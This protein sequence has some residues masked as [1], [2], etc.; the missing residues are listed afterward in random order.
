MDYFPP[1]KEELRDALEKR[2]IEHKEGIYTDGWCCTFYENI[3]SMTK[4]PHGLY[5]MDDPIQIK[6]QNF[7]NEIKKAFPEKYHSEGVLSSCRLTEKEMD[8]LIDLMH[9]LYSEGVAEF[10]SWTRVCKSHKRSP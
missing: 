6:K 2:F 1:S 8:Q 5:Y 10:T 9:N 7:L 4:S 3:Y